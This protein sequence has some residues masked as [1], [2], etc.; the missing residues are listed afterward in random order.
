MAASGILKELQRQAE[1]TYQN[2][3]A[4]AAAR[5]AETVRLAREA[6]KQ[7]VIN[8]RQNIAQ[9]TTRV[10]EA[11]DRIERTIRKSELVE[12]TRDQE[13]IVHEASETS[14]RAVL[15]AQAAEKRAQEEAKKIRQDA[16]RQAGLAV[17]AAARQAKEAATV[18]RTQKI[19]WQD[20]Q[21]NDVIAAA[22]HPIAERAEAAKKSEADRLAKLAD[23]RKRQEAV[24]LARREAEEKKKSEALALKQQE[25]V[26][27]E[28]EIREK[29][30]AQEKAR[31]DAIAEKAAKAAAGKKAR[32]EALEAKEESRR[33]KEEEAKKALA[34][35]LQ[36]E[37]RAKK[38][39]EE[40]ARLA[41]ESKNKPEQTRGQ[42]AENISL[43]VD[44][45]QPVEKNAAAPIAGSGAALTLEARMTGKQA[46]E[47]KIPS[48]RQSTVKLMVNARSEGGRVR[49]LENY[50]R[51]WT[52]VRVVM[53]GGEDSDLQIILSVGDLA[54]LVSRLNELPIVQNVQAKGEVIKV[55]L[56]S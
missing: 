20:G 42:Q 13:A 3:L 26:S 38:E 43:P 15:Q 11:R 52:D 41:K 29:A 28:Q 56:K 24:V 23:E 33:L 49:E 31:Q 40:A 55:T 14:N 19:V 30:A 16:L 39:K 6:E 4:A 25:R 50:L 53:I 54:S 18:A 22:R 48:G 7:A 27:R 45:E 34:E 5:R 51:Q 1:R 36:A 21:R 47:I 12:L 9:A 10:K 37:A 46:P 44:E 17:A 8:A 35:K 32:E 2:Q